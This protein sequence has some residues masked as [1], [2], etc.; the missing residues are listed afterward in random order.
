MALAKRK[1]N[2]ELRKSIKEEEKRIQK[3]IEDK[4]VKKSHKFKKT[5]NQKRDST[6]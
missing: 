5:T 1:E 2:N 3:L 4:I 6:R